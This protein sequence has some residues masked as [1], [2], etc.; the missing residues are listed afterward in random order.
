MYAGAVTDHLSSTKPLTSAE[1]ALWRSFAR[2]LNVLPRLLD[3]ELQASANISASEYVALASLADARPQG[4]RIGQLA[5]HVGLSPSRASR[6]ADN[7]VR[8]GEVNRDRGS[9]DGRS[10]QLTIS[11]TGLAR[12]EAAWPRQVA[13]VRRHVLDHID[14]Q[15]YEA[16]VRAF[17]AIMD[18]P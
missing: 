18:R 16:L 7:L 11:A 1:E 17:Q 4:L 6:L 10:Q 8:R 15:D 3:A 12:V 5:E 13:S 9:G 2:V 14:P